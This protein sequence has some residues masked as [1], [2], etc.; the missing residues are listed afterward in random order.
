MFSSSD[1]E[2]E[3]LH[4]PNDFDK[5]SDIYTDGKSA[6]SSS[7]KVKL[8]KLVYAFVEL[9]DESNGTTILTKTCNAKH[10]RPG[11]YVNAYDLRKHSFDNEINLFLEKN[12]N[13]NIIIIDKVKTKEKEKI[14]NYLQVQNNNIETLKRTNEQDIFNRILLNNCK[15]LE[16]M[17]ITS[18]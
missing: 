14:E 17:A 4:K 11:D 7:R 2:E 15:A 5:N 6:K 13:Y 16:N 12:D 18:T 8:D 1:N 9:Y 3:N 10:L